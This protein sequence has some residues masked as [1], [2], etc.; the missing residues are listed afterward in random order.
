MKYFWRGLV[1][2][3]VV[4]LL[5]TVYQHPDK[6]WALVGIPALLLGWRDA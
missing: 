5:L 2:F 1:L 3:G 6:A 4:C